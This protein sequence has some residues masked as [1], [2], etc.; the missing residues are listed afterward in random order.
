ME[1]TPFPDYDH[2]AQK[3]KNFKG[4]A[5][6]IQKISQRIATINT[7]GK[8]KNKPILDS[9]CAIILHYALIHNVPINPEQPVLGRTACVGGNGIMYNLSSFDPELQLIMHLYLEDISEK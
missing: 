1:P 2:Y 7:L 9:I 5:V 6:N 3:A 4:P 8:I